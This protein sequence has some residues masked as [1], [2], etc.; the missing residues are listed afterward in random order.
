M[1][2]AQIVGVAFFA[3]MMVV[4]FSVLGFY[5]YNQWKENKAKVIDVEKLGVPGK[6]FYA[7][8]LTL[9]SEEIQK[10]F[11]E[12]LELGF[13]HSF[14][15]LKLHCSLYYGDGTELC[16]KFMKRLFDE[17]KLPEYITLCNENWNACKD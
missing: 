2:S 17:G 14:P 3:P 1:T 9:E 16:Y 6:Q 13:E 8:V 12:L 15:E 10:R 7:L 5:Y 4:T 11:K